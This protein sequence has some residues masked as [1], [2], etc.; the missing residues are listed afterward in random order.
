MPVSLSISKNIEIMSDVISSAQSGD[1]VIFP[2]GAI[3]G[4]S[5]DMSFLKEI[6]EAEIEK[7]LRTLSIFA[8]EKN[9]NIWAG[10]AIKEKGQWFNSALGF[11]NDGNINTYQKINLANAERGIFDS[12]KSL[13][14]FLIKEGLRVGVQLCRELRFPEQWGILARNGA[15]V[16][17]HLNNAIGDNEIYDIWRSHLI[18]RAAETQRFVVSVNNAGAAQKCPTIIIDPLG[19]V[20]VEIKSDKLVCAR[21]EIDISKVSDTL[22]NQC[23]T[24]I[25]LISAK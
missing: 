15:Q 7:S 11:M 20:L 17:F 1:I 24:D 13:P 18:S 10:S 21:I 3:S 12:G 5:E 16:F 25:V 8:K 19:R 4:Y 14:T 23:R 9:L 6:D 22:I 2:E